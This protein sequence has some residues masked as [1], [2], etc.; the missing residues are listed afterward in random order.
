[1]HD[2]LEE[3]AASLAHITVTAAEIDAGLRRFA[4]ERLLTTNQLLA[5]TD[6]QG[7]TEHDLRDEIRQQILDRKLVDL[8]V[9]RRV[10]VTSQETRAAYAQSVSE[11][12][13]QAPVD[14]RIIVFQIPPDAT[15]EKK[16]SIEARARRVALRAKGRRRLLLAQL[17]V[18]RLGADGG[19][20]S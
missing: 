13:A 11:L 19:A 10:H 12:S 4:R 9:H 20:L 14:L 2:R 15:P 17:R 16:Q 8:R 7:R 3:H 6:L 5:E 18:P 1:M